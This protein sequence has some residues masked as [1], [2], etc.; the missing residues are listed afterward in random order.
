[1]C[2][3]RTPGPKTYRIGLAF[4]Q[5]FWLS[6]P[7]VKTLF[8]HIQYD[9]CSSFPLNC[10]DVVIVF[11]P[12]VW[13]FTLHCVKRTDNHDQRLYPQSCKRFARFY[14][15]NRFSITAPNVFHIGDKEPVTISV[16]DAVKPVT[17]KL[18]LQ[19]YANRQKTFSKVQGR[20]IKG[21]FK[22]RLI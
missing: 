11:R 9:T 19:D 18:Y 13:A 3:R 20:V 8:V 22:L 6:F 21:N 17:V 1:M 4:P 14:F 12:L 16:F 2:P 7:L 10:C 5:L 15:Y